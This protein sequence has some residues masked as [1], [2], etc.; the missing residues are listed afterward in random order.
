[1]MDFAACTEFGDADLV[2]F[3]IFL[4]ISLGLGTADGKDDERGVVGQGEVT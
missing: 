2:H 3:E 4:P 1:M